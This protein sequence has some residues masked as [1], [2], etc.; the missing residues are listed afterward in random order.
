MDP[1]RGTGIAVIIVK[2]PAK[3]FVTECVVA[4][5]NVNAALGAGLTQTAAGERDH[6]RSQRASEL[7]IAP[8]APAV[9]GVE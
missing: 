8:V 2:A 5:G 9:V 7:N 3:A 4:P 1:L 6:R